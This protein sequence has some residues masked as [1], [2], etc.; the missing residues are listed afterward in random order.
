[1]NDKTT[2]EGD[3]LIAIFM[4]LKHPKN[5]FEYAI[6]CGW[7]GLNLNT[8]DWW[9]K[10]NSRDIY[11]TESLPF[12]SS[13]EWL[14]PVV[15]QINSTHNMNNPYRDLSYTINYLLNAGYGFSSSKKERLIFTKENL[16]KRCVAFCKWYKQKG[17]ENEHR[18]I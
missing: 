2:I 16:W 7:D 6:K 8:E 1:M 13:W 3:R 17:V 5:I 10:E 11:L 12:H 18:E 9:I 4:E 14:M 15:E